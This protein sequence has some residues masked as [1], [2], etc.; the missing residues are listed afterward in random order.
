M[1]LEFDDH[2]S[3]ARALGKAGLVV[4]VTHGGLGNQLFQ[5]LY[6]ELSAAVHDYALRRVHDSRYAHGFEGSPA[7]DTEQVSGLI[8][9][10]AALRV[11]KVL[12]RVG[13]ATAERLSLPR[14]LLLD[15]YFQDVRQYR[16]FPPRLI[17]AVVDGLRERLSI[18]HSADRETLYHIRLGDFFTSEMAQ[19][20]HL[21]ERLTNLPQG[22][23]VITN[24]DDLLSSPKAAAALSQARCRHVPSTA[25]KPEA[26]IA[27]MARYRTIIANDSTLALWAAVFGQGSITL[28]DE[29]LKAVFAMLATS[30][31]E[32]Y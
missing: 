11:P 25:L 26:L 12:R 24:R 5:M 31:H 19:V 4:V 32:S 28:R 6:G 14:L 8:N 29:R 13:L 22:S 10:V 21:E 1:T 18:A 2:T 15:G 9:A 17:G 3:S 16:D 20:A 27:L 23:D 7:L 30:A